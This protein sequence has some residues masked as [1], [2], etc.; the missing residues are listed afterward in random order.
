M[1]L[2]SHPKFQLEIRPD[3]L[4]A[5]TYLVGKNLLNNYLS[6]NCFAIIKW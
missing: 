2:L 3:K 5:S 4:L 1:A 6:Q